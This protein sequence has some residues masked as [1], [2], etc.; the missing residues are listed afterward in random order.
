MKTSKNFF[1]DEKQL[2]VID[3]KRILYLFA[4]VFSFLITEAGRFIYRPFIYENNIND[5]GIADSIGN[6]GGI[7]VQIFLGLAILN[8]AF[9]KGFR[10]IGLFVAG[11]IV[12]EI[13]QPYLPKGTFD[14]LDIYG[15]LLGGVIALILYLLLNAML[16]KNKVLYTFNNLENG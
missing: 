12:Y 9:K 16:K 13:L 5:F 15:T 11:Y 2:R 8:P 14:W 4:A 3:T 6:S 1:T 10:L 7:L